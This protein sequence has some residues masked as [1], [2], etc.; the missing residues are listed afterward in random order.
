MATITLKGNTI[1]TNGNLPAI[2]SK[3]PD[4]NL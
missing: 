1:H 2:G 3:A 4:F